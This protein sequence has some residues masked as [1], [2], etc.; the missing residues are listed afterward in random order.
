[1]GVYSHNDTENPTVFL[2][3]KIIGEVANS[4]EMP[5]D[6]VFK[7][8]YLHEVGHHVFRVTSKFVD[9][10]TQRLFSE[11][12]ANTFTDLFNIDQNLLDRKTDQQDYKYKFYRFFRRWREVDED[13]FFK[14][15]TSLIKG[16]EIGF[17][18]QFLNI[19]FSDELDE[20][21][22]EEWLPQLFPEFSNFEGLLGLIDSDS[23]S[24]AYIKFIFKYYKGDS[25]IDSLGDSLDKGNEIIFKSFFNFISKLENKV[26]FA[27]NISGKIS[28]EDRR[29]KFF[30]GLIKICDFKS[31]LKRLLFDDDKYYVEWLLTKLLDEYESPNNE[32]ILNELKKQSKE[33]QERALDRIEECAPWVIDEYSTHLYGEGNP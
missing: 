11:G 4:I 13:S 20:A 15:L 14:A 30:D 3:S 6:K 32:F 12:L 26:E 25:Q 28:N 18:K 7:T 24:D 1:M 29:K 5:M 21:I 8:T 9:S 22:V 19:L 2:C 10:R 16:D 27:I 33:I 17:F 31:L 23:L